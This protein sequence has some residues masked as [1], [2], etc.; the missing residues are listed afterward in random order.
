FAAAIVV[1]DDVP[2]VTGPV[3]LVLPKTLH[4]APAEDRVMRAVPPTT[5]VPVSAA[6]VVSAETIVQSG[7][8]FTISCA[9]FPPRA[10]GSS[11][12]PSLSKVVMLRVK[13]T[14]LLIVCSVPEPKP[15]Q[16]KVLVLMVVLAVT[17][18]VPAIRSVPVPVTDVGPE[19]TE[20]A[21]RNIVPLIVRFAEE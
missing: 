7:T 20:A 5:A 15:S 4:V 8:P 10:I 17:V 12:S 11:M 18:E 6:L 9:P 14:P 2:N 3:V 19:S 16:S 13:T 21:P 1:T